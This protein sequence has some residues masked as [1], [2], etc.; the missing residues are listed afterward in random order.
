MMTLEERSKESMRY[1]FDESF[2]TFN[3][4]HSNMREW[5]YGYCQGAHEQSQLDDEVTDSWVDKCAQ[6]AAENA[7][8]KTRLDL[9]TRR[10]NKYKGL[11]QKL[12]FYE[13]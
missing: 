7:A 2:R 1:H 5:Q 10:M 3:K 13:D 8:L 12:R 6:L 4:E 11:Y 9:V